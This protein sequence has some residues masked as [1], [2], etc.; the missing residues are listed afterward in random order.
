MLLKLQR[1]VLVD[2][3]RV[4]PNVYIGTPTGV[5]SQFVPVLSRASTVLVLTIAFHVVLNAA[6]S[7]M[8]FA[9]VVA[10]AL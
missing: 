6:S 1:S 3:T 9:T 10:N 4:P 5:V 2:A 8:E 7:G